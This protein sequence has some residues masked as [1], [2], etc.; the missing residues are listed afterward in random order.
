ML[1]PRKSSFPIAVACLL[2]LVLVGSNPVKAGSANEDEERLVH[3]VYF[4]LKD[5]STTARDALVAACHKYL[6]DHPGVV[7]FAAGTRAE[8][9]KRE[10][11][12]LSFEVS[13]HIV[14]QSRADH[15]RYQVNERHQ[16]FI[17]ENQGNWARVRVFD[18]YVK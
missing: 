13:L 4:S 14:F 3:D 15:D 9:F 8:D 5:A 16:Q 18:S 10:V 2:V 6:K 11:N 12:D 7:F 1:Y 17:Q